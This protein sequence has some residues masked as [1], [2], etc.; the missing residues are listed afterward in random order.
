MHHAALC[1][2]DFEMHAQSEALW[3][4]SDGLQKKAPTR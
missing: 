4:I 2:F 3:M 1:G